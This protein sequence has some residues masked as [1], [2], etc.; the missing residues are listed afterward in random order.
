[1]TETEIAAVEQATGIRLPIAY[2]SILLNYPAFLLRQAE[3]DGMT[4]S[5]DLFNS[6]SSLIDANNSDDLANFPKGC[7]II[8]ENGCGDF[9]AISTF[10]P[11]APVFVG[12][13]HDSEYPD[14]G[15]GNRMPSYKSIYGYVASLHQD[16]VADEKTD[17]G[18]SG[19]L[20]GILGAAMLFPVILIGST[21][22]ALMAPLV[23]LIL[24]AKRWRNQETRTKP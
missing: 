20:V 13:A 3:A 24:W 2:R 16:D 14:D 22:A 17:R 1:M 9:Y 21:L 19:S 6:K 10:L 11:D 12:G 8:G 15:S 18:S 7:F 4:E 23:V 5:S